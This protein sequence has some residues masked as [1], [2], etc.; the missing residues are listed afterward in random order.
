VAAQIT[1]QFI[2]QLLKQ[3][4][5]GPEQDMWLEACKKQLAKIEKKKSWELCDLPKGHKALPTKWVFDLEKRA[6][7]VVCGNFEKKTDVETFAAVVN[8]IMVKLFFLVVA[9]KD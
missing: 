1:K 3:V 8:M 6:R 7:L 9:I 4:I 5:E 2:P